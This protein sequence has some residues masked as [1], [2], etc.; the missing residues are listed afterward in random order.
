MKKL[1]WSVILICP[2]VYAECRTSTIRNNINGSKSGPA[3]VMKGIEPVQD[4]TNKTVTKLKIPKI[5]L[6]RF[7]L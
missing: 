4:A 1:I 7:Q 2:A 5:S 6:S 3:I